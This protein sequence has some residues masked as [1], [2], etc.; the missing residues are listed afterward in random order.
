M[1]NSPHNPAAVIL[2][3]GRHRASS[4]SLVDGTPHHDHQRRGLRA[5]HLRRRA[6]REHGAPRAA[7]RAQLHRRILRQDL[8][9]DRLEGRLRRRAG[10]AHDRVPQGAPVR[11]LL[12]QHARSSTRSRSSSPSARLARA[13]GLLPAQ[14]GSLP[15]ADRRLALEAA[16]VTRHLL[17]AARLLGDHRREGHGLRAAPDAGAR[18]RVDPDVGVPLQAAAAAGAALL[19]REEGRDARKQ[20]PRNCGGCE[21]LRARCRRSRRGVYLRSS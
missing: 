11:H 19:L 5:H 7:A 6:P 9:R 1:L 4:I 8:S 2:E 13:V 12:D 14:A 3:R 18:R 21:L 16:A 20:P 10:G 15:G 17:P